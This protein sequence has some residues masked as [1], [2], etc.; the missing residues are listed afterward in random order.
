MTGC[1]IPISAATD[2]FSREGYGI[3]E[4][5]IIAPQPDPTDNSTHLHFGAIATGSRF[6]VYS[7]NSDL[8]SNKKTVP[9]NWNVISHF[10]KDYDACNSSLDCSDDL[11]TGEI[12]KL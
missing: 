3:G 8:N 5:G 1:V 10:L 2:C 12:H 6:V 11:H 9:C 7:S 4:A